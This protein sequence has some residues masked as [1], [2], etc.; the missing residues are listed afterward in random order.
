[1]EP[2][3]WN[4]EPTTRKLILCTPYHYDNQLAKSC[5]K[6]IKQIV[7]NQLLVNVSIKLLFL[8]YEQ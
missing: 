1:M 5:T 2:D 8:N 4:L 7:E 3:K 6:L